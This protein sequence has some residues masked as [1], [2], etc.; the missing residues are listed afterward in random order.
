MLP[1][2]P[3]LSHYSIGDSIEPTWAQSNTHG[4]AGL[5]HACYGTVHCPPA[6]NVQILQDILKNTA[7]NMV[8]L[9]R[10][11]HI[12]AI[13]YTVYMSWVLTH[14][15]IGM[16]ASLNKRRPIS[17]HSPALA[18]FEQSAS[19]ISVKLPPA[20]KFSNPAW[21]LSSKEEHNL[22]RHPYHHLYHSVSLRSMRTIFST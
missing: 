9:K 21:C 17:R 2:C 13:M 16:D 7:R 12:F 20:G 18:E 1:C 22:G 6:Y 14:I 3:G 19:R 5:D 8:V 15:I 11:N 10:C 4:N